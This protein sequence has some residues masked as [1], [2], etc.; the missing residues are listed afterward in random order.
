[1]TDAEKKAREML[2]AA[3]PL[4]VATI[5]NAMKGDGPDKLK[6]AVALLNKLWPTGVDLSISGPDGGPISLRTIDASKLTTV[7]LDM[8]IAAMQTANTDK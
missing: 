1:M 3:S 2:C 5:I 6:A 4:A 8:M 7:Q